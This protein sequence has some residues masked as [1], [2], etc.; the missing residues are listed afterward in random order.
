MD[1]IFDDIPENLEQE[2]F[3]SLIDSKNIKIE[4][5]I[6]KGH[7]SPDSGWYD[8]EKNEWIIVLKGAAE[9]T[10]SD[11]SKIS[12]KRGDHLNIPAHERHRVSWTAPDTETIWLAVH[13]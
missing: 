10:F 4:R 2:I 7:T 8:Q 1:N 11:R 6:S 12:L 3:N 9:L 13:Y 5:I